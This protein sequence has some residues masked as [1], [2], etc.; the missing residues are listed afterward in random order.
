VTGVWL[1]SVSRSCLHS[2][3]PG[4]QGP[5]GGG[6]EALDLFCAAVS[7]LKINSNRIRPMYPGRILLELIEYGPMCP[8]RILLEL[9]EYGPVCPARI[10]LELIEYGPMCP[11]RILLELIEYGPMFPVRILL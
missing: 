9:I 6:E 10:L 2:P 7:D 4:E 8:A 3:S 1:S 11:A 5:G